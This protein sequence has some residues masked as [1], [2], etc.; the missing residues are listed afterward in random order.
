[1]NATQSGIASATI[2]KPTQDCEGYRLPT[3]A[4]WEYAIRSGNEYT[5]FYQCENSD[6][7]ITE[8]DSCET[9]DENLDKIAV[10]CAND[11]GG[12]NEIST[13][14]PNSLGIFD[15]SGNLF[16]WTNDW[17]R[18]DYQTDSPLNPT[19][20]ASGS[21]LAIRGGSW[22]IP[23]KYSRSACRIS[24]PPESRSNY[25]GFRLVRTT[26]WPSR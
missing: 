4:E 2:E 7:I 25:T 1:M 3:E 17:Y 14:A 16:E 6:G 26:H 9:L 22:H 11:S 24:G 12:V 18:A 15:M 13:K 5:A 20:L 8:F 21:E 19:G 10:Y 23:A